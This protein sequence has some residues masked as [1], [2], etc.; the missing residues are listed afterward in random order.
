MVFIIFEGY[1]VTALLSYYPVIKTLDLA[2][3]KR[4]NL[5]SI[6]VTQWSSGHASNVRDVAT[7]SLRNSSRRLPFRY[8]V[9]APTAVSVTSLFCAAFIEFDM[10]TRAQRGCH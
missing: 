1:C 8:V 3:E 5:S 6:C 10:K 9:F 4:A 2:P 7:S